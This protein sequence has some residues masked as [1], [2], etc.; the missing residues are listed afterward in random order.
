LQPADSKTK[1]Y[2][3]VPAVV[4]F[5]LFLSY[6]ADI[7]LQP[8]FQFLVA[9]PLVYDQQAKSLLEGIPSSQPFFLSPLYP[10][11]L[12]TIYY[13]FGVSHVA[14]AIVQG[15]L[16]AINIYLVGL[17]ATRIFTDRVGLVSA[18]MMAFYWSF[19]YFAGEI[20]PTTLCTTIALA[21]TLGAIST[22]SRLHAVSIVAL[23]AGATG[24]AGHI[25]AA[26]RYLRESSFAHQESHLPNFL[27]VTIFAIGSGGLIAIGHLKRNLR[28][29]L[30][31]GLSGLLA[32][33]GP[34][35]WG[36]SSA[37]MAILTGRLGWLRSRGALVLWLCGIAIPIA[38]SLAHNYAVSRQV[39]PVTTSFGVNLFIGNNEA[40][41]GM[42]PFRLGEND[43]ARIEADHLG[44]S[45]ARRSAF[46]RRKAIEFIRSQP[47]RWLKLLGRKL[48]LSLGRFEIDNNADISERQSVWK[49]SRIVLLD[50]G[51]LFPLAVVGAVG[52]IPKHRSAAILVL[53]YLSYTV[54]CVV[55]FACERFRIP[56]IALLIPLAAY[57]LS[58]LLHFIRR[59]D[60]KSM[61]ANILLITGVAFVVN[62]DF[63]DVS[64]TEFPSIIVNKA[65]VAR[66]SGDLQRAEQLARDVLRQEPSNA[67]AYFQ[68][69][70]I[71]VARGKPVRAF[72]FFLD[73]LEHDPFHYASYMQ[74]SRI[75]AEAHISTTYLDAYLDAL[76][77]GKGWSEARGKLEGYGNR[78]LQQ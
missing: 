21:A 66:L 20:L 34:L 45:G 37:H 47:I 24:F 11:F 23:V 56:G 78:R 77:G 17:I 68:L 10:G 22:G 63:L 27:L 38:A 62:T 12:A 73:S 74:A 53:G 52:A 57:G 3:M 35:V 69:G 15:I 33:I 44:L 32:G 7:R 18:S 29:H 42:D 58:E 51:I 1:F 48:I 30:P 54:I 6:L 76:I 61:I 36:G 50:L 75:L 49:L 64:D 28:A 13:F 70:A 16:L 71:E 2:L 40:S 67:G 8:F 65:H 4:G 19:Y 31:A 60:C 39:I 9:N 14:V 72:S 5:G 43:R 46:F 25:P 26:I 41:D 59:R 55:F